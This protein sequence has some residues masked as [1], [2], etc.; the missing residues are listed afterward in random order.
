MAANQVL[1]IGF[2]GVTSGPA[3]ADVASTTCGELKVPQAELSSGKWQAT[4]SYS[5]ARSR[6][7]S[8][9][10]ASTPSP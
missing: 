9:L 7:T 8:I 1:K 5:S 3:S 2:V 10:P 4:I 6:G